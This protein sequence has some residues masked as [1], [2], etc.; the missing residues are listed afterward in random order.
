MIKKERGSITIMAFVIMLFVSLFGA[1][2]LGTS[3]RKYKIQ[4]NDVN[5]I[6]SAYKIDQTDQDLTRLYT[7]IGGETIS[8]HD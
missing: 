6:I 1:I 7:N 4:T 2:I 8:L 3:T 5:T